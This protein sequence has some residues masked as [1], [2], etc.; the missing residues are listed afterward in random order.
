MRREV[1]RGLRPLSFDAYEQDRTLSL[2]T[3]QD[4]DKRYASIRFKDYPSYSIL[5]EIQWMNSVKNL[6]KD[7]QQ[8]KM[9]AFFDT[10]GAPTT[11]MLLGRDEDNSVVLALSDAQGRPR[12]EMRVAPDGTPSLQMLDGS[13]KVTGEL[14]PKR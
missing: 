14:V 6:P 8:A 4:G 11:R 3:H 2:D 13:G 12:I 9:K 5:E 7:Q 1:Y 10:H